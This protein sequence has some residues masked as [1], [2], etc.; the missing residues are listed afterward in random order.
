MQNHYI[1]QISYFW[2]QFCFISWPHK[3]D[4]WRVYF[5][6]FFKTLF[7]WC[8]PFFKA[9]IKYVTILIQFYLLAFWLWVP[10]PGIK[11]APLALEDE[12]LITEGPG[13]SPGVH[14]WCIFFCCLSKQTLWYNIPQLHAFSRKPSTFLL[15]SHAQCTDEKVDFSVICSFFLNNFFPVLAAYN[16]F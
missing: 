2:T 4:W 7:F 6:H 8:E 12:F 13:K 11:Q 9:F 15:S 16:I 14:F 3:K 1:L 5:L 10:R